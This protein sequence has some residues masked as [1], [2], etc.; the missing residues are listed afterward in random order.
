MGNL[1][2]LNR[3]IYYVCHHMCAYAININ[4]L[5]NCSRDI[6]IQTDI[7][8]YGYRRRENI[9]TI[10]IRRRRRRRIVT[11]ELLTIII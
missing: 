8:I 1:F 4:I 11:I 7:D 5:N 2:D 6:Y 9:I 10:D 3:L